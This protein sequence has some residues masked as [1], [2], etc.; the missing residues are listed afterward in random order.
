MSQNELILHHLT[1]KGGITAA[2]AQS[3][4]GIYRLAA[5]I[6]ELR[7]KGHP[8]RKDMV[9]SNNREGKKVTFARYELERGGE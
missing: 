7:K 8:I 9:T 3:R 4:Y 5:R 1:Q 6:G 2:E